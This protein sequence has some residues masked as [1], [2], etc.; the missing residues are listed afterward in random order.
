MSQLSQNLS[1]G[2]LQPG[3]GRTIGFDL[4]PMPGGLEP[5]TSIEPDVARIHDYSK[6][7][8]WVLN[9]NGSI[10]FNRGESPISTQLCEKLSRLFTI[11]RPHVLDGPSISWVQVVRFAGDS[12]EHLNQTGPL[13]VGDSTIQLSEEDHESLLSGRPWRYLDPWPVEGDCQRELVLVNEDLDVFRRVKNM[14][15]EVVES[16][17]VLER[18]LSFRGDLLLQTLNAQPQPRAFESR[19]SSDICTIEHIAPRA[20]EI[21]IRKDASGDESV[22]Q[23]CNVEPAAGFPH[24][25]PQ[26]SRDSSQDNESGHSTSTAEEE[27]G[28]VAVAQLSPCEVSGSKRDYFV[29]Q[30]TEDMLSTPTR[31]SPFIRKL[32]E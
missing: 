6:K 12:P 32:V 17:D 1:P 28:N 8:L 20:A 10:S 4:Q 25:P 15:S 30:G 11:P 26:G 14:L 7:Y 3:A 2:R 31:I 27:Y 13:R 29:S 18:Q 24:S 16:L 5:S 19:T 9:N 21:S 22:A 23:E